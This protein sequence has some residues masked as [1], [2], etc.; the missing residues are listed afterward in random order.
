MKNTFIILS[1]ASLT[2]LASCGGNNQTSVTTNSDTTS[3]NTPED[4]KQLNAQL[5]TDPNDA[6]LYHKRAKYYF[7]TKDFTNALVDMT[8]VMN[9]DSSKAEYFLTLS[10]IYFVTN[11]TANS[12][13]ALE[14]AIQLDDKN[15]DAMLKLAELYLYVRKNDK[16][17][18]YINMVLK[19]NQYNSKAYFMKGMNYKELKDTAKA[20]SSMQ[21]AVEQDQQYYHAYM[22]L[23]LLCAAQKNPLATQYYKNALRIQPQSTEAWYD[24]GKYYQDIEDWGNAIATYTTLLKTDH[25]NKY[26]HYNMGVIHLINLK[27]YDIAINHFTDAISIDPKYAEAYYGR[28]ISY[29]SMGNGV[30]ATNDFQTCLAINAQYQPAQI[31]LQKLNGG[32]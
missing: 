14:K 6:E 4:L 7:N 12:K 31:A 9:I 5:L 2:I 1:I 32:K 21:T 19:I 10:D 28:G 17:L 29:Q 26:A 8:K 13:T 30:N 20:I 11:K 23:G 25:T 15:T 16:S 27:K 24:L 3:I 18:E 22:Q